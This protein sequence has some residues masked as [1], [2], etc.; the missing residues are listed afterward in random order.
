MKKTEKQNKETRITFRLSKSEL[1]TLNAKMVEAGYKSAGAFIRDYVANGQV[2]PKVTQNIVQI[3]RELMNLASMI[4]AD[5]P[6]SE[7]LEKV[8][9][10]A[11]VNFGG[12]A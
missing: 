12:V 1:D 10:I 7:L 6:G 3:A 4:N 8:K 11:Q 9:Y 2:K 5:R